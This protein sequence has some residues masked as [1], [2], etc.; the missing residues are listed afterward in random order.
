VLCVNVLHV[1]PPGCLDALCE[2]AARVLSPG[3]LLALAGP[4]ARAGVALPERLA[5]F[6]AVLR[7]ADPALG[8]RTVDAVRAAARRH[9]LAPDGEAALADEGDLL[10]V[11]RATS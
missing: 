10:L 6:D 5:R 4:F 1:A 11:F 2:G 3:G 9:G 8:V 7:A